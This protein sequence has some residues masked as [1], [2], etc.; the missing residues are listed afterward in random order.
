[1]LRSLKNI[2]RV[3]SLVNLFGCLYNSLQIGA[4]RCH[5][6]HVRPLMPSKKHVK[7]SGISLG[8]VRLVSV[9]SMVLW[10]SECMVAL[11]CKA[12][13]SVLVGVVVAVV[14]TVG[15]VLLFCARVGR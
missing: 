8:V 6:S 3:T 10:M 2:C 9:H 4:R 1:M 7:F 13:S 12:I 15:A 14:S 11:S 5:S